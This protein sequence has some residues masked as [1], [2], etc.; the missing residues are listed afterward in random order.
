MLLH[1]AVQRS[2]LGAVTL[3]VNQCAIRYPLGLPVHGLHARLPR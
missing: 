1:L 2:L 3:V